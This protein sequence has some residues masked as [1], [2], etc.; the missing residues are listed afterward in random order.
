[1]RFMASI[2]IFHGIQGHSEE[3]WFPW[4]KA[5]LEKKGHQVFVPDFPNPGSPILVE[6]MKNMEQY[7]HAVNEKAVFIGHSLGAAFA[8]RLLQH[9]HQHI[10]AAFLVAPVWGVMGNQF[11]QL[12]PTFILPAYDWKALLSKAGAFY[13]LQSDN[14]PYIAVDKTEMLARHL[15]ARITM[16]PRA[17]HFNTSAG[18]T[19]FPLLRELILEA[20]K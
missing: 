14:D 13:I 2:F 20:I 5:E 17:A 9:M 1:M 3:N 4:L 12:M 10:Q 15:N 11:D 18:Y 7:E 16:V 6:W 8:L 19:E